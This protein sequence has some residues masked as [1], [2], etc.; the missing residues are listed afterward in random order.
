MSSSYR[1]ELDRWISQL[2]VDAE[3]V[4]DLGGSQL[5]AKGRTKSWNVSSYKIADLPQPHVGSPAPDIEFNL[6]EDIWNGAQFDLIFCLEVFDYIVQPDAA[7]INIWLALKEGGRAWVS[8]PFL[9]PTHQPL[10]A[11]GLRYTENSIYRLAE[12]AGLK[13]EQVIR[14]RPETN[15]IEMLWRGERMRAA[16]GYDH[17]VTGWIV[18]LSK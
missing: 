16:K 11:E 18:E 3:S 10:E 14:R 4:L 6:E 5:P 2:D 13:V 7:L 1:L 8:F 12:L 9:Y 15:A 17:N